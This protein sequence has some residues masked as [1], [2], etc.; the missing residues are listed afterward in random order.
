MANEEE[1]TI[2]RALRQRYSGAVIVAS[3]E[4]PLPHV[5][6]AAGEGGRATARQTGLK[7]IP[8]LAVG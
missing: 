2:L 8:V 3:E 4:L 1:R 7:L 5:T 6:A